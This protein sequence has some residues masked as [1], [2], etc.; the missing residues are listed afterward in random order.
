MHGI[1]TLIRFLAMGL[2]GT[3]SALPGPLRLAATFSHIANELDHISLG[4]CSLV[5][6]TLP[7]NDTRVKLP[8]P[9]SHLSL[10]YVALGRGTQNY[11]CPSSSVD[12]R[13][14]IA[15]VATGAAAT[16]FDASCLA[17]SSLTLL[18]E[19]PAVVGNAPL[20]SLA[21]MAELL[22]QVT[23]TSD[24]ILGEHYFDAK[25]NPSFDLRLSNSDDWMIS[26]KTASV[27]APKRVSTPERSQDVPWLKLDR[28][29]G[30]GIKEVYRVMTFEGGPPSTCAGLNGTV[31]VQYAAEYWFYG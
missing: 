14:S 6:A 16:L 9:S 26:K 28:K 22:S 30:N 2:A 29:E 15:P 10:K 3:A 19:M 1:H 8:S 5:N 11:S 12:T 18:H 25:G 17:A 13:N 4:N 7:L 20:G 23:N 31:L 24:I 21:F 27:V